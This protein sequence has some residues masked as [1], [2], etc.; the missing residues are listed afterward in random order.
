MVPMPERGHQLHADLG[1]GVDLLQVVD[2]LG[3]VLDGID[4]VMRRGRDQHHAR[5]RMAQPRDHL[6]H[7]EAGQLAALAG[8]GA[9]GHL[10]LELAALVQ[11]FRGHAEAARR[12]LLDGGIGVVAIGPRAEA[13]GILAA[14]AGIRL[15]A[16]A[17]HGDVEGAM[18][19]GRQR[20][21]RHAGGHE[22]L[23]DLGD[24]FDLVDGDRGG[25]RLEGQQVA[26]GDG[27]ALLHGL[28]IALEGLVGF[29]GHGRLQQMDEAGLPG[30]GLAPAAE[31][32]EAADG[33]RGVILAPGAPMQL[34]HPALDARQADA[35][36]AATACRGNIPPPWCATG[37]PPR[38]S[39]R[40]DRR[41]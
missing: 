13:G 16:D 32:V 40:R 35:R 4:V 21:Q 28:G 41:R 27:R 10:D 18:R 19:L 2:E 6:R 34:E 31:A 12:H 14:L 9:L 15:G 24:R 8:L 39:S 33:Q 25:R 29:R 30:M 5:R 1:L 26:D 38:R 36:D 11:I 20:A 7:L 22:A 3:Q 17:V 37:P 23:A